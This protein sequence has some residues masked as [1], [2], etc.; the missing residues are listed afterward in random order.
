MENVQYNEDPHDLLCLPLGSV[1]H[2]MQAHPFAMP[3][4]HIP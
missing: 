4:E 2:N 1:L 3:I